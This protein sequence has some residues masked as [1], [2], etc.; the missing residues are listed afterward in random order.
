MD[1]LPALIV[2]ESK[3]CHREVTKEPDETSRCPM[4]CPASAYPSPTGKAMRHLVAGLDYRGHELFP[5]R[6]EQGIR[7][8]A[9]FVQEP[10]EARSKGMAVGPFERLNN[11]VDKLR[12]TAAKGCID[13]CYA[14]IA[15]FTRDLMFTMSKRGVRLQP[16]DGGGETIVGIAKRSAMPSDDWPESGLEVTPDFEPPSKTAVEPTWQI[17]GGEEHLVSNKAPVRR[18]VV[19]GSQ[20][21]HPDLAIQGVIAVN[22][23]M[24][25]GVTKDARRHPKE[26]LDGNDH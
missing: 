25:V 15:F 14:L 9:S 10:I 13:S 1:S 8:F 5:M 16:G 12:R 20:W 4:H 19:R 24:E 23:D 2:R 26:R 22:S 17:V 18:L 7:Q 21:R 3:L 6:S 11:P